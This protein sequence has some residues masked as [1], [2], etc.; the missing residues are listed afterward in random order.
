MQEVLFYKRP[1]LLRPTDHVDLRFNQLTS[2]D[3]ARSATA[4]PLMAAEFP[5]ACTRFPIVFSKSR[6]GDMMSHAVLSLDKG[7]NAFVNEQGEWMAPY[8]PLYIRRYPF[9]LANL[10]NKPDDF[11]VAFD[12]DSSC[13]NTETGERLFDETGKATEFLEKEMDY[14]RRSHHEHLRTRKFIQMLVDE[15][16]LSGIQIDVVRAR[17]DAKSTIRNLLAVDEKKLKALPAEKSQGLLA[18]GL[19]AIIYAHLI[20]LNNFE[21]IADRSGSPTDTVP[22]RAK[23]GGATGN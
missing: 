23:T 6:D 13:F 2:L 18:D 19:M 15:E 1:E 17:D 4:V 21:R 10:A 22:W 16:L 7:G 8:L 9:V 14:L 5:R 12:A 3:F 20:S 11:A